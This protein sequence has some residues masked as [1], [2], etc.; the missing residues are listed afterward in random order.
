[1]SEITTKLRDW[2]PKE[3]CTEATAQCSSQA[4]EESWQVSKSAIPWHWNLMAYSRTRDALVD[5]WI[6]FVRFLRCL[7]LGG[8]A[9]IPVPVYT[10][11]ITSV[12]TL[13]WVC[14]N[15]GY[16][17]FQW[18]KLAFSRFFETSNPLVTSQ[19]YVTAH[20]RTIKWFRS[21][22]LCFGET[23]HTDSLSVF[24]IG[25][26][27]SH[28]LSKPSFRGSPGPHG[29]C[30]CQFNLWK[31]KSFKLGASTAEEP[32]VKNDLGLRAHKWGLTNQL[33][34]WINKDGG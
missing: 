24:P 10:Q 11:Y 32:T 23:P 15:I 28:Q 30:Q 7:L 33:C 21:S 1:M 17:K 2:L 34:C 26:V 31:A 13:I 6:W 4:S 19:K 3:R 18:F 22:K 27:A 8:W 20:H 29:T 25:R 12:N 16:P 5:L 14:L 9:Y